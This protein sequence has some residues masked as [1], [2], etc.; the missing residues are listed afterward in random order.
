SS[1]VCSSDLGLPYP[2]RGL[3]RCSECGCTSTFEIKKDKY[4]YGHCTQSKGK[5]DARY[6]NQDA[7]TAELKKA[8]GT[9]YLPKE[10]YEQVRQALIEDSKQ[11]K[12]E[13][14]EKLSEITRQIG[15][16]EA[17]SDKNYDLYL[18]GKITEEKYLKKDKE[19]AS[20]LKT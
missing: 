7:I 19:L 12:S 6:V 5:H 4:I 16:V 17:K 2:Y 13:S 1:D 20:T 9:I 8:I 10:G 3:I 11:V 15:L 14:Q 18:D